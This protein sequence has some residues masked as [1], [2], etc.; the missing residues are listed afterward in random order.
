MSIESGPDREKIAESEKLFREI[1]ELMVQIKFCPDFHVLFLKEIREYKEKSSVITLETCKN[2]LV[3]ELARRTDFQSAAIPDES[4]QKLGYTKFELPKGYSFFDMQFA[5][6]SYNR[7]GLET[8]NEVIS[9]FNSIKD[10]GNILH[11]VNKDGWIYTK[12]E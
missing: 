12:E 8:I 6:K 11:L 10:A 5:A 1:E 9:A 4:I 3:R 7:Y 2:M